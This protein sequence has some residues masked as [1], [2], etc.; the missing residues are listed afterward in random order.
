VSCLWKGLLP[1]GDTGLEGL[2]LPA[3]SLGILDWGVGDGESRRVCGGSA[4][5]R[6]NVWGGNIFLVSQAA[7][8]DSFSTTLSTTLGSIK[9][10]TDCSLVSTWNVNLQN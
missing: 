4:G 3:A 9:T 1:T 5:D 7:H 10:N 2:L 8:F 6:R